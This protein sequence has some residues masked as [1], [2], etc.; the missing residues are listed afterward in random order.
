MSKRTILSRPRTRVYDANYYI[1][2]S[3]Y[4]PALDRLNRKYTGR[5][6]SPTRRL[7][8]VPADIQDRHDRAFFDDN[9][10]NCRR[11]AEKHIT[12]ESY[13]DSRG[14]RLDARDLMS[15]FDEETVSRL[16]SIRASKKVSAIDDVGMDSTVN[17]L[18]SRRL[19]D[20]TD[21][22]LES[23]GLPAI[24]EARARR[25]Y[26]D[27]DVSIKRRSFRLAQ[28]EDSGSRDVSKWKEEQS[29]RIES[30][31]ALRAKQ[32]RARLTELDDESDKN[33]TSASS[34]ARQS[35]IRL[36]DLDEEMEAMAERQAM[37]EKKAARLRALIAEVAE[38]ND[39]PPPV[40][41]RR[42]IRIKEQEDEIEF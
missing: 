24:N 34:R 28:E 18:T 17:N 22:I 4:R 36:N 12:G 6:L 41:T 26:D 16:K 19:L 21:K 29:E 27:E 9:I 7:T 11:R 3:M 10:D 5:P 42:A 13:F 32:T 14:A 39:I 23:V 30:A 38:E 20:R 31:A 35:K 2:E 40:S 37:R 15:N 8:S 33:G 1:G 25:G